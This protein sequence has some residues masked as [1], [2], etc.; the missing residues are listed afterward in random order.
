MAVTY[1]FKVLSKH[2]PVQTDENHEKSVRQ[3]IL[4]VNIQI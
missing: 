3:A 1:C 2:C 4:I